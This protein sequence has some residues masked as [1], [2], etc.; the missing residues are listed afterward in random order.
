V[1]PTVRKYV[2]KLGIPD[3]RNEKAGQSYRSL[4]SYL[5][6]GGVAAVGGSMLTNFFGNNRY[7]NTKIKKKNGK[8]SGKLVTG[9]E[10]GKHDNHE[11]KSL[12]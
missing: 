10:N 7:K 9:K 12:R 8:I 1:G 6:G 5:G 3:F 2:R 11:I 4:K